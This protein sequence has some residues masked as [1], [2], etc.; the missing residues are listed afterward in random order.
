VGALRTLQVAAAAAVAAAAIAATGCGT[1]GESDDDVVDAL[2]FRAE[3]A[4]VGWYHSSNPIADQALTAYGAAR[5]WR[6][7]STVDAAAFTPDNLARFDVIVYLLT[8]GTVLDTDQRAALQG[9]IADGGGWAGV[10]SASFTDPDWDW[11]IGL[12]GTRFHSEADA[13]YEAN[14]IVQNPVAEVLAATPSPWVRS[15]QWYRFTT[16]PEDNPNL[17]ILLTLDEASLPP[18]YPA[19]LLIGYHPIAWRQSYGGGRSFYVS[20]GHPDESYAEPVFLELLAR[21]VEWAA[22]D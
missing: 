10:H 3:G 14:V 7:E 16:R 13:V 19:E 18:G 12:V 17:E 22:R 11:F 4:D 21:G 20:M 9:F 15:D 6:I 1:D 8:S 5:G 2:F